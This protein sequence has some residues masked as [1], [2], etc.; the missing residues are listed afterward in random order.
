MCW[1]PT[2]GRTLPKTR[3]K[4]TANH[5]GLRTAQDF[6]DGGQ[7]R[8]IAQRVLRVCREKKKRWIWRCPLCQWQTQQLKRGMSFKHSDSPENC[9]DPYQDQLY[10]WGDSKCGSNI[11]LSTPRVGMCCSEFLLHAWQLASVKRRPPTTP[12][13]PKWQYINAAYRI[14][15]IY[16]YVFIYIIHIMCIYIYTGFVYIPRKFH[17]AQKGATILEENVIF[18]PSIFSFQVGRRFLTE[19]ER[20]K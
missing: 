16:I 20:D 18:Q 14:T 17:V 9:S 11:A 1:S 5:H 19:A 6:H 15:Y 7:R 4:S 3:A 13:P 10:T 2:N 8:T 12:Y